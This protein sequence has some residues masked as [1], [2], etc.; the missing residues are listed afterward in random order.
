MHR[1][2]IGLPLLALLLALSAW[3]AV[4]AS[5]PQYDGMA[6]LPA[7]DAP[8]TVE[9]D[10]LGSVTLRAQSRRDLARALGYVH[11][12]ERFF[13]M[14]L[15]RR[16]A[17][18]ELAELF[19]A[20]ALPADRETRVHRM[21]AR[22]AVQLEALPDTQR[23]LL[24]DYRDGVNAGL[25]AL[26]VRPF[27]YLLT[28]TRPTAWRSEDS[29][30]VVQSMYF[31]LTDADNRRE[32]DLSIL[33][34]ALPEAAYRFLTAGG[35]EWDAPL[36]GPALERP[37]LPTAAEWDLRKQEPGPLRPAGSDDGLLPGSNSFAVAGSLAQ[38]ADGAALVANDM[39]LD[40]RVPNIWFRTRLIHPGGHPGAANDI[41]GVSLPGTPAIVV[42]SNRSIAWS[43]TNSYSDAADW[44]RVFR[45]PKD[46]ARYRSATGGWAPVR[47]YRETLRVRGGSD[48]MLDIHETEWGPLLATD[49]DGVS[50]ALAWSAHRPGAVNLDLVL[51]EQAASVDQAI[52]I[53]QGAGIP[54]QNFIVGDR[55]GRIGWTIAGRLPARSGDYDPNLPADWGRPGTGWN[56]W[57]APA[58]YPSVI[59]PPAQRLW[60]AN[61]RMVEGPALERIGDAGYDLGAR[62]TQIRDGLH[63]AERF[64]PA[65]MLA[66]QL[67]DRALFL[68]GWKGFLESTLERIEPVPWR[69]EMQR[70]LRDWN[71][72]AATPSVAYRMVR[73]FRREVSDTLLDAFAAAVRR[74][75]PDFM[76]PRLNQSEYAIQ[77][78]IRHR[79]PHL[80]P[81]HHESWDDLFAGCA[82]RVAQQMR[83]Q[84]GGIARRSWGERN[85]AR[86]RHP[87][88]RAL[89]PFAA[90]WLDMPGDRLPGDTHMPRV[91]GPDFGAS[92]RFAVA[93][94]REDQGYFHMPG[95][96]SGHP[97]SP[98]YGSGHADWVS[99]RPTPFLPGAPRRTLR[100]HP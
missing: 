3:Q 52:A 23:A 41:I 20:A 75:Y 66:I 94:G 89:P 49:H 73:A 39:H 28:Q 67:D 47:A 7:L 11:A 46:A 35:G 43:F 36:A 8:V 71:G 60:S 97:L 18:G 2:L 45:H 30:L 29:I 83:E 1:L 90:H 33:R 40:L 22:A 78:L 98:Y 81:P 21:R 76:L 100:L 59:D 57:L 85:T 13:E 68:A 80:L 32:L 64:P 54:A 70:A 24:D 26:A 82:Q 19:G 56:G 63:A 34:A 62:A 58:R 25:D 31:T 42:G 9:R 92:Q 6:G 69:D 91:Q 87:L 12:Q 96:Q 27:P 38:G 93:P 14:D 77:A 16:K 44:V 61:A 10:A 4:R 17:A 50:L 99:G 37:P 53:V 65:A 79:P 55:H 88:S 95:G 72:H 15:M 5:L 74:D 48:E 51:L 84:P 86:I